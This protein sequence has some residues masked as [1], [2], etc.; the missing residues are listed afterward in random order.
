M[1]I[2]RNDRVVLTK[3]ITG[4]KHVDGRAVGKEAEG[5]VARVLAVMPN[6]GKVVVEGINFVYR[7]V[8][9]STTHPRGGRIPKEAAIDASNVMLY[10]PKCDGPARVSHRPTEKIDHRG[11]RRRQV[12]RICRRCGEAIGGET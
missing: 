1:R 8:R 10:C 7:H 6:E 2:R 9:R 12:M 3:A 4:A 11:K 5:T